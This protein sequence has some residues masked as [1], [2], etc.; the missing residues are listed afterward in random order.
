MASFLR[1][2]M[3]VTLAL[4]LAY[5]C[6]TPQLATLSDSPT[7]RARLTAMGGHSICLSDQ[8]WKTYLNGTDSP[9]FCGNWPG[10]NRVWSPLE[11]SARPKSI[12]VEFM[13]LTLPTDLHNDLPASNNRQS[14]IFSGAWTWLKRVEIKRESISQAL[15]SED[16]FGVARHLLLAE[17]A[18][19]AAASMLRAL[20]FVHILS[21][22]GIHLY[23]IGL[24]WAIFIKWFCEGLGFRAREAIWLRRSLVAG[25]WFYA[26]LLTGLKPGMLRPVLVVGAQSSAR[27]FGFRW[28]RFTPLFLAIFFDL[29]VGI[30]R[31]GLSSAIFLS[32]DRYLYALAVGGGIL[33]AESFRYQAW[34][35]AVG[36]WILPTTLE[37]FKRGYFTLLTPLVS[38]MSV[39]LVAFV[40]YPFLLLGTLH[41]LSEASRI[42]S[43]LLECVCIPL[44]AL[45]NLWVIPKVTFLFSLAI[46]ALFILKRRWAPFILLS[47]GVIR[48][49]FFWYLNTSNPLAMT[50]SEVH[51]LD[52]GQGDA[53]L[54]LNHRVGEKSNAGLIDAGSE[55]AFTPLAWIEILARHETTKID[56]V[57]LTHLDEDHSGGVKTLAQVAP[58]GCLATAEEQLSSPRGEKYANYLNRL[59]LRP[60]NLT[61]PCVPYPTLAPLPVRSGKNNEYMSAFFIPLNQDSFYL[62]VG[63]ADIRDEPRMGAWAEILAVGKKRR[64]LKISH[65]GSKT[66]TDP[67]FLARVKPTQTWISVGAANRYGHPAPLVLERLSKLNIP[68]LRTDR[69][70]QLNSD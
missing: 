59:G 62:T 52:V 43:D 45:P 58:I 5:F 3:E 54:V 21:A 64:I 23:A 1:S 32:E 33:L 37:I 42:F 69:D 10:K 20:G 51:Q 48:L 11:N 6:L 55:R 66:S 27:F 57:A 63:D 18:Q 25:C 24:L 13:A 47:A 60:N 56:W 67:E 40:F 22:S 49:A 39:P 29:M 4:T 46:G 2:G 8:L 65:H 36:S 68:I 19:S 9:N 15:S 34:A 38:L 17:S 7:C 26:W 53:A 31:N 44:L 28:R 41:W 35:A 61:A 14:G 50:A 12:H 30:F 70:G 16:R